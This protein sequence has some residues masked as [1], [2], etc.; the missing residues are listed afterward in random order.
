MDGVDL[1]SRSKL[2]DLNEDEEKRE[3]GAR[4]FDIL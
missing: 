3:K 4:V 1:L 2:D